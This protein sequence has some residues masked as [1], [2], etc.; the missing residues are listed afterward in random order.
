MRNWR[1]VS[2]LLL[3]VAYVLLVLVLIPGVGKVVN[4]SARWIDLGFFN[5]QPSEPA[6]L[7]LVLYLAAFLE[8]NREEVRERWSG[9]IKPFLVI[10]VAV[11][12][13]EVAQ[14]SAGRGS[15]CFCGS[16]AGHQVPVCN[17][18]IHLLYEP[19]GG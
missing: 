15:L 5:L 18:K 16:R 13:E 4:G 17:R 2:G 11:A 19:L 8:R 9:F 12:L 10:G 7:F 1:L 14:V 6:K 3:V